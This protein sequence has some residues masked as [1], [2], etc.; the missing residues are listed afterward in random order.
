MY[1]MRQLFH[2]GFLCLLLT[3]LKV[4]AQRALQIGDSFP[5]SDFDTVITRGQAKFDVENLKGKLLIIDFWA[6]SCMPCLAAMPR[7]DSLKKEFG[8]DVVII[9][10]LT[11]SAHFDRKEKDYA[12]QFWDKNKVTAK[13]SLPF[14]VDEALMKLFP[15]PYASHQVWVDKNGIIIAKTGVEYV[16]RKNIQHVLDGNTVDFPVDGRND[17]FN[18]KAPF[19][20]IADNGAGIPAAVYHSAFASHLPQVVPVNSGWDIDSIKGIKRFY[21]VNRSIRD[22]YLALFHLLTHG[23]ELESQYNRILIDSK[24]SARYYPNV[25]YKTWVTKNTFCYEI[26]VPIT[27][28]DKELAEFIIADMR[29]YTGTS[30]GFETRMTDCFVLSRS[31]KLNDSLFVKYTLKTQE[32]DHYRNRDAGSSA[33]YKTI[34]H[35]ISMFNNSLIILDETKIK[36]S[37]NLVLNF[38]SCDGDRLIRS[39]YDWRNI[40]K[41]LAI[42]GLR[43]TPESRELKVFVIKELK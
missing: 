26:T 12:I 8:E 11:L 10:A 27:I 35:F 31:K 14:V 28:S 30:A 5:Y 21:I 2:T 1:W 13:I 17:E 29:R 39:M 23:T 24:D 3:G 40:Q 37:I 22:I 25:E 32:T 6:P 33:V 18:Y 36:D 43:L 7:I 9:T 42:Y 19:L 41:Q 20:T 38:T 4:Q 34:N 16:S 15:H